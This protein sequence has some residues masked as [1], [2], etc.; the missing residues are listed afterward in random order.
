M[1]PPSPSQVI[2]IDQSHVEL[3]PEIPASIP[4]AKYLE[5]IYDDDEPPP[6]P[7]ISQLALL[8][9][10]SQ[11]HSPIYSGSGYEIPITDLILKAASG[12]NKMNE[13]C[14][15]IVDGKTVL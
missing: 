5:L 8:A 4:P 13:A 12:A 1:G 7:T 9:S 14:G 3:P 15:V 2:H 6:L 11:N 10:E